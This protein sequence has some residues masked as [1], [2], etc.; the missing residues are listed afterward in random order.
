[1]IKIRKIEGGDVFDLA[2]GYV[3][4]AEKNNPLFSGK[5]SQT[6]PVNF[7]ASDKN[8]RM[9]D[10]PSRIDR[11]FKKEETIPVIV[12]TGSVQ[13]KGLLSVHSA[14]NRILSANIGYDE[15]VMYAVMKDVQL[16]DMPI[17]NDPEFIKSFGGSNIDQR[18]HS[19]LAHLTA[20]MK[21]Q[22][23]AEYCVF[24]VIVKKETVQLDGENQTRLEIINE[25]DDR[26]SA[27]IND[28]PN[29][30]IA[31][32]KALT[33]RT[34]I[35][36]ENNEEI[37]LTVPKG[38]GVSPFL[39]VYRILEII[40]KNFEFTVIENPFKEHKQLKKL[41]VLNNTIDAVLTGTLYYKDLMPDC[42]IREFL[43][44]LYAK[45]GMLYFVDSTSKTIRI[46]FLKDIVN[47]EA[48][49]GSI[50]LNPIKTEEPE[51]SFHPAK[52][53]RLKMN[54]EP[55][56]ANVA[57]NT[58]EEFL[59]QFLNQFTESANWPNHVTQ[60]FRT[61]DSTYHIENIFKAS[62]GREYYK[63]SDFFDWD[64]KTENMDYEEVE[65][66]DICL[67]LYLIPGALAMQTLQYLVGFK[68]LYSDV[69]VGGTKQEA[70][71]A[72]AKIAFAFAWGITKYRGVGSYSAFFA[73]QFNRDT[74]GNF[75]LDEE[76]NK[77]GISLTCNRED[78]LYNR[79]W[80]EYDAFLRHS[81]QPVKCNLHL[82]DNDFV[83]FKMDEKVFIN[84]Q[85]LLVE[86]IK[87]KFNDSGDKISES[88]FRTLR[89]YQPY[90]LNQEQKIPEY[91]PQKYYWKFE[92]DLSG[93][94]SPI[95]IL[96]KREFD[97][98]FTVNGVQVPVSYLSYLPPTEEQ[99]IAQETR[100]Y[101]RRETY[102]FGPDVSTVEIIVTYKP[103]LIE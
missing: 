42:S 99:Y 59:N 32:L 5:G 26:L 46:K 23:L 97:S 71:G 83:K 87:Y 17:L 65:M 61:S 76:N 16:K 36:Y 33:N 91:G 4:E 92:E 24:P 95:W 67:P 82:N 78:G 60:V 72:K 11:T 80:K 100:I 52:Q 37:Q 90:D 86:Q 75:I 15:S 96:I 44:S 35:R 58:M 40:F 45:F 10:F 30:K 64:K 9:L 12:E 48:S 25:V 88:T 49:E 70:S 3:I 89:L 93:L 62:S 19:M 57:F 39:K 41:V 56:D 2:E 27:D 6:V 50:D 102:R 101:K 98:F 73:S 14:S 51:I 66:K 18:I 85:P 103:A 29:G 22:T 43:D 21:E 79:F 63:S 20:V 8:N 81:N 34:I 1:M 54:R 69:F 13:Q 31:E 74:Q 68:H 28:P 94:P 38:Y 55:E 53:L 77:Y 7:P 47:P 84:N